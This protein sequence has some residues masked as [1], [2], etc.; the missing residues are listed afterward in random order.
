MEWRETEEIAK[1]RAK[2]RNRMENRVLNIPLAA[3]LW[4]LFPVVVIPIGTL[5]QYKK[6]P[7]MAW[8]MILIFV[9]FCMIMGVLIHLYDYWSGHYRPLRKS[10]VLGSQSFTIKYEP[11]FR[12]KGSIKTVNYD[13]FVGFSILGKPSGSP[14]P[15]D[16]IQFNGKLLVFGNR[17]GE[18]ISIGIPPE[19]P[20]ND[21]RTFLLG[22]LRE[23]SDE[24]MP[25]PRNPFKR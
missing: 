9:P 11:T 19:M 25:K 10:I 4:G 8:E 23:L 6:V 2:L 20:I 7:K 18:N 22:K 15:L 12:Y 13:D 1:A 5:I 24:E 14:N 3:I 17:D 21:V 16:D